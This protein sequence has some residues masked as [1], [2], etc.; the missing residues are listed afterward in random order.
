MQ[1]GRVLP[2]TV[3]LPA[4]QRRFASMI[5]EFPGRQSIVVIQRPAGMLYKH[6]AMP[7]GPLSCCR[8]CGATS[9]RPVIARDAAGAMTRTG[10]HQ[11]SGCSVVFADPK[12][13]REGGNEDV[14]PSVDPPTLHAST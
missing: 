2:D 14:P 5:G 12:A 13:W 10:L 11:C 9:Y 1:R 6:P 8:M 7:T 3:R 4:R